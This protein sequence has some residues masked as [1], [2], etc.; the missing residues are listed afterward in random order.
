MNI[1]FILAALIGTVYPLY[2]VLTYRKINSN[3][4]ADGRFRLA[5]YKQTIFIFW[6]ITGLILL[7]SI[8]DNGFGLNFYPHFN[9]AAIV[10]SVLV[11]AFVLF[12]A[13]QSKVTAETAPLVRDKMKD[14]YHYLPKSKKE[15][16]WFSWLSLSAGVCEE[17]IFRLF[18]FTF[19]LEHTHISI[20]FVLTNI[21]F[22][23]THIGS[24][25]QNLITSF[26]L[27]LL[28]SAIYYF[29]DNIWI[30]IVLH[31]AIDINAGML[32]YSLSRF[33]HLGHKNPA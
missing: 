9:T 20:A 16:R 30:A 10:L 6:L 2:F 29:T 7:N 3:I 14:I 25:R 21:I 32:G 11:A 33:E 27:G 5:D 28:L 22:A 31:A 8:S 24:G 1:T 26:I 23:I 13:R 12:Q 19:L 4:R 18:L 15:L 17:I